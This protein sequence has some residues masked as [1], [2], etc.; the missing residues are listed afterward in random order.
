MKCAERTLD[1]NADLC[2]SALKKMHSELSTRANL[3]GSDGEK[4]TRILRLMNSLHAR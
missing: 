1:Y 4:A 3:P 2:K